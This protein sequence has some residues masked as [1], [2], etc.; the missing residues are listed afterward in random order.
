MDE[1]EPVSIV[2]ICNQ[3]NFVSAAG[4]KKILSQ[5]PSL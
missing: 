4:K 3:V 2:G 5:N 1:E